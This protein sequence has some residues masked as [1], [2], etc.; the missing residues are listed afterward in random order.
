MRI[1]VPVLLRLDP[2]LEQE[3]AVPEEDMKTQDK[4]GVSSENK[5]FYSIIIHNTLY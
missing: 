3:V 4:H 2:A 1:N 5:R